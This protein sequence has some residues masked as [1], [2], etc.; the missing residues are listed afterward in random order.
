MCVRVR[1]L[2]G[3]CSSPVGFPMADLWDV[4]TLL[5]PLSVA[6]SGMA[7]FVKPLTEL[8][9]PVL[10]TLSMYFSK[11]CGLFVQLISSVWVSF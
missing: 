8:L 1:G 7:A 2:A 10:W 3:G 6:G 5:L 4:P 11:S 9:G